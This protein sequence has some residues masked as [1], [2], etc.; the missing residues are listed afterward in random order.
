MRIV[1]FS[2]SELITGI[3]KL[4]ELLRLEP[5]KEDEMCPYAKD[6]TYGTLLEIMKYALTK[7]EVE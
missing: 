5:W 4:E 2:K 6:F 1:D 3:K 7:K